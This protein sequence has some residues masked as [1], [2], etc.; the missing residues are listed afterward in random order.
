MYDLKN[1]LLP[2]ELEALL[3]ATGADADLR[4]VAHLLHRAELAVELLR[5]HLAD[6]LLR[7]QVLELRLLL[8][9]QRA[10]LLR[11][12]SV[13]RLVRVRP[14]LAEEPAVVRVVPALD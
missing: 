5:V 13:V 11:P 14:L 12:G 2:R 4:R 9:A 10:D 8:A 3:R 1:L 7:L 6:V